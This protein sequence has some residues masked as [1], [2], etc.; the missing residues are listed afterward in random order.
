MGV[1]VISGLCW[2]TCRCQNDAQ[3]EKGRFVELLV[4]LCNI[5]IFKGSGFYETDYRSESYKKAAKADKDGTSKT[6]TKG[7]TKGG[8]AKTD[9]APAKSETTKSD[10]AST[11]SETKKSDS[12]GSKGKS[13]G[14]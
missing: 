7:D 6:E 4:S 5:A 1:G 8:E 2:E 3:K 9:S 12:G 10:S 14:Q 11:K 13:S